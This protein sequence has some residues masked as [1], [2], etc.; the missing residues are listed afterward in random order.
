MITIAEVM[1]NA[2]LVTH[3]EKNM[4]ILY[5]LGI[6]TLYYLLKKGLY[7]YKV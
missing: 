7:G 1:G 4:T 2:L 5:M 3:S 6:Q